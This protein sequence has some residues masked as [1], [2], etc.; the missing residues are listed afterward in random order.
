M[1]NTEFMTVSRFV[2]G[3]GGITGEFFGSSEHSAKGVS[4]WAL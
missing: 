4:V 3:S 2:R 1:E